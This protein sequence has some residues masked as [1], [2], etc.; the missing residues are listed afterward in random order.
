M[1]PRMY[2]SFAA[3]TLG[4]VFAP[5]GA[6]FRVESYSWDVYGGPYDAQ[7]TMAGPALTLWSVSNMLR[8][9]V[10]IENHRLQK[11]WWGFVSGVQVTVGDV[12]WGVSLDTIANRIKVLFTESITDG[13]GNTVT[14]QAQ[15]DWADHADSINVYGPH[16][17][18]YSMQEATSA[19]AAALRDELL[20]YG[21]YPLGNTERVQPGQNKALLICRGYWDCLDTRYAAAVNNN[22]T[23]DVGEK[24]ATLITT[25]GYQLSG[26]DSDAYST[27]QTTRTITGENRAKAEVEDLLKIGTTTAARLMAFVQPD[28]RVQ[29]VAEPLQGVADWTT[30]RDAQLYDQYGQRVAA[31][32]CPVGVWRQMT[33][34]IPTAAF[35]PRITNLGREFIEHSE[36]NAR[37]GALATK[38]RQVPSVW[39]I[40]TV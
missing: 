26:V 22:A 32:A 33:A 11:R 3:G 30:G 40:G 6:A 39:D 4:P 37:T 15:T 19:A 1:I 2:V 24:L 5:F 16:E 23:Q 36:Y 35:N 18:R 13:S 7:I 14:Q 12:Q 29:I 27:L 8:W 31:D 20:A 28:K 25:Y 34:T 21:R 9:D 17:L 38:A 10:L